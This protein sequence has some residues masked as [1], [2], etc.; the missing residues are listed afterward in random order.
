MKKEKTD[1][2]LKIEDLS[3][4]RSQF[5][6]ERFW[7][8]MR[9]IAQKTGASILKPFLLLYYVLEDD[10]VSAKTK[11]Y[12]VGALGYFIIPFDLVPDFIAGLGFTDD[13][14]VAALLLNHIKSNITPEIEERAD[15]KIK[16][17]LHNRTG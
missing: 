5:D 7:E 16:E 15:T 3:S 9:S 17:W 14:A 8:K 4:Y 6:K 1:L 12:I 2:P 10:K 13:L 11:A